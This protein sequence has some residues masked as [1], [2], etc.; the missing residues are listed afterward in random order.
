[1][2][3]RYLVSIEFEFKVKPGKTL[4][5]SIRRLEMY[6]PANA[7]VAMA[8]EDEPAD[9]IGLEVEIPAAT[10]AMAL[11]DVVRA[12][13]MVTLTPEG[14]LP[15][16]NPLGDLRHATVTRI[17]DAPGWNFERRETSS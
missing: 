13:E 8:S 16:E 3:G 12:V 14:G 11:R 4:G 10:P 7:R 5:T 6:L 2:G 17:G 1:M 9:L 15:V